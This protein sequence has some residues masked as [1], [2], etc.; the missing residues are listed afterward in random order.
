MTSIPLPEKLAAPAKRALSSAGINT[1]N[2]LAN[3]TES[4]ILAL[5][6]IGKNALVM[7]K[8]ALNEAG[9]SFAE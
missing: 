3:H 6:G 1:L 9:L 4:E 2:N 7:L 5:H 8:K